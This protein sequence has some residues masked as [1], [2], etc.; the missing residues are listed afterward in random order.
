MNTETAETEST[1]NRRRYEGFKI[2]HNRE[3]DNKRAKIV[4]AP[5]IYNRLRDKLISLYGEQ[6]SITLMPRLINICNAY[7]AYKT[8]EIIDIEKTF[9]NNNRFT[10]EDVILITYG[11]LI[12]QDG[13]P[14]LTTLSK[15]FGKH[16]NQTINTLHILPFF[17][18]SS[19]RGFSVIDFETVDPELGTWENIADLETR[20]KLMFDGVINHVSSKSKWFQE[21]LKGND[22]YE[23]FFITYDSYEELPLYERGIILRPRTSDILTEFKTAKGNRYVWTTFSKDQIDLNYKNPEVLMRVIEILLFYVRKGADI[24]R[25]DAVT[26]LWANP[27]TTCANLE[28]THIIVR[29]FHD[30]LELVA[31]HVAIIT[32]SN[33]PHKDNITYF[34]TGK[35]EA[36]MIYNFALPPLVLHTF[37]QKDST[38]LSEWAT[39][40]DQVTETTTYFNFLDSHDGIGLMAVKE[41]LHEDNINF[42]IKNAIEHGGLISYKMERTG[43]EIPYELNI[44]WFSALNKD[45]DSEDTELQVKRFIASRAIALSLRGVPGIYIHSF[46]GTKNDMEA[47]IKSESESK[48]DINRSVIKYS[49]LIDALRNTD[50]LTSKI[51]SRLYNLIAIRIKHTAFH[52]NASQRILNLKPD[53]FALLRV[54][55][56]DDQHLISL[57][58]ITDRKIQLSISF[59]KLGIFKQ[60][61]YDLISLKKFSITNDN[62]DII[63]QPYDVIWLKAD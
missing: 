48:R 19:D 22:Y 29:L 23:K 11:D 31:P 63:L 26:Y 7:C 24:I 12:Q 4:V 35:D 9:D 33:I 14:P 38:K 56:K 2:Q 54:S 8:D 60:E 3:P 27:G 57:I 32:E 41:I 21:F 49:A 13:V 46:F 44:T 43:T 51:S 37:Y 30:I 34:G 1:K 52:P 53:I 45:D 39:S 17:P 58:N 47:V 15:F 55:P 62:M 20:Y 28:Q 10:E 36:H 6:A 16:K 42:I 18:Y 61:W 25:L 5:D 50:S 40:L 59:N